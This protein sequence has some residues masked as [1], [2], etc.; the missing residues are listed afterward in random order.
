MKFGRY[1]S[2]PKHPF[3]IGPERSKWKRDAWAV[4]SFVGI[5]LG[6][7]SCWKWSGAWFALGSNDIPFGIFM[8][9][10]AV[11]IGPMVILACVLPRLGGPI[12]VLVSVTSMLVSPLALG[13]DADVRSVI[14]IAGTTFAPATLVGLGFWWSGWSDGK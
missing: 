13:S 12:L 2:W 3:R 4:S 9:F 7:F 5:S 11:L 8:V 1:L 14:L 6:F 10:A